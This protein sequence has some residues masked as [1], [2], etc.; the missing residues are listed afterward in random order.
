MKKFIGIGFII[1]ASITF[2]GCGTSKAKAQAHPF[3]VLEATYVNTVVEQADLVLTTLKITINNKEIKL[4]SVFFRNHKSPLKRIEST[5]NPIFTGG[6]T[7][8]NLPH[9]Y[10][11]HSDPKQE[12][13]NKP[14]VTSSKLPFELKDHEAI[15]SYIY[16][17][18]IKYYKISKVKQE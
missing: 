17:D 18:K 12:F 5:E 14:P 6:F 1:L 10:I 3:K 13:G 16:K 8:S 11:L 9:D 7:T 2:F 4:D 15:V